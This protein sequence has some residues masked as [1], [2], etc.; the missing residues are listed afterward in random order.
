MEK[1]IIPA[2]I[3]GK[4][5]GTDWMDAVFDSADV[6]E[7]RR[8]MLGFIWNCVVYAEW[9]DNT[10]TWRVMQDIGQGDSIGAYHILN[11]R[12]KEMESDEQNI[13]SRIQHGELGK[14]ELVQSFYFKED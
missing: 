12:L 8:M 7:H 4:N 3:D 14:L 5:V 6:V 10:I 11:E 9:H 13:F 2:P 1:K